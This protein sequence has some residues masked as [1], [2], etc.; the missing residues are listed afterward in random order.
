MNSDSNRHICCP[1]C[2][3]REN[4]R[5]RDGRKKCRRCGKKYSCRLLRSR[6]PAKTLKQLA[7]SF[8]LMAPVAIV[9]RELHL[10]PK[11][12]RRHYELMRQG[13]SRGKRG[14]LDDDKVDQFSL[15]VGTEVTEVVV[16]AGDALRQDACES[17]A[18][19]WKYGEILYCDAPLAE[20][21]CRV[22]LTKIAEQQGQPAWLQELDKLA[23]LASGVC[24][25]STGRSGSRRRELMHE[26]AFRFNHRGNP[27]ASAIL[28]GYFKN[29]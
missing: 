10:N 6:L 2:G 23:K 14:G 16:N 15:L 19:N 8:W 13:I 29:V 22:Y 26:C 5:L 1:V 7:L 25:R 11:T 4:Y 18:Y 3:C 17:V 20:I 24:R 28:Y 9:A 21:F 27:G 12:V